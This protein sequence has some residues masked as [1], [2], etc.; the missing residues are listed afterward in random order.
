MGQV[1]TVMDCHLS[2]TQ[3][4][5]RNSPTDYPKATPRA[6][7]GYCSK[8]KLFQKQLLGKELISFRSHWGPATGMGWGGN[9]FIL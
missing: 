4:S 3:Q 9:S 8:Q 6:K 1:H 5:Q 2:K 7:P